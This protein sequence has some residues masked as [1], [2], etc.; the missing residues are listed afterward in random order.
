MNATKKQQ[1]KQQQK[2]IQQE[3]AESNVIQMK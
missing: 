2:R 3:Y 1:Q